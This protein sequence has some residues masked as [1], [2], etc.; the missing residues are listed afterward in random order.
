MR[1]HASLLS[2]LL[3]A[4]P[5]VTLGCNSDNLV[6]PTTGT[7]EVTTETS[8]AEADPD[9][10]LV[11]VDA[12]ATQTIG[13]AGSLRNSNVNAGNHTVQLAGVAPNCG[14]AGENPRG[15]S[16]AAGEMTTVAFQVSCTA[17]VAPAKIAFVSDRAGNNDIFIM[18]SDGTGQ[19]DLIPTN[20]NDGNP[21]WSPDGTR[22]AFVR[23]GT[24]TSQVGVTNADGSGI[25]IL[26]P[27]PSASPSWSPD[28]QKL[29]LEGVDADALY[30]FVINADGTGLTRLT[31]GF[32]PVWAPN[33]NRIAFRDLKL[34]PT[35]AL[36][37]ISIIEADGSN[38]TPL[39]APGISETDFSPVWSP[40]G[41]KI[42]FSRQEVR[43]ENDDGNL[44]T[45]SSDGSNPRKLTNYSLN[46]GGGYV[47]SYSWSPDAARLAYADTEGDIQVI[48]PD[49]TGQL[50][51]TNTPSRMENSPL[52][53]PDGSRILFTTWD[54]NWD[55]F[56]M[57]ADGSNL[58]NLTNAP[59]SD[60]Q[61]GWQP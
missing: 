22:I 21:T 57:N 15:V 19:T 8:G 23:Y 27:F 36:R 47:G 1:R 3:L 7:L 48:R 52:W 34:S 28:S 41:S 16:I 24:G 38:Y 40:D 35:S 37:G 4:S 45:I 49:G 61:A 10:Y 13:A 42:A 39:T 30:V 43:G 46:A 25:T 12:G 5:L 26:A 51:L 53:S 29:A 55:I 14:V 56:L 59:E 17:P 18:N 2:A 33:G 31:R 32:G 60:T 11:Q 44:W 6:V 20:D 50:N 58:A 54:Q 9:G